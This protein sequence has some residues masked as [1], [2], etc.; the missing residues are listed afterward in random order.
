VART[1]E[2]EEP[3]RQE[4]AAWAVGALVGLA[5]GVLRKKVNVSRS[6]GHGQSDGGTGSSRAVGAV[7]DVASTFVAGPGWNLLLMGV[8]SARATRGLAA[9]EDGLHMAH[10]GLGWASDLRLL[11]LPAVLV[12][13]PRMFGIRYRAPLL[14]KGKPSPHALGVYDLFVLGLIWAWHRAFP[15]RVA[16]FGALRLPSFLSTRVEFV[17]TPTVLYLGASAAENFGLFKLIQA[18]G[19]PMVLSALSHS[20]PEVLS[21]RPLY[22]QS[23]VASA[24]VRGLP[25]YEYPQPT[26]LRVRDGDWER[27]VRDLMRVAPLVVLDVRTLAPHVK[28]EAAWISAGGHADKTIVVTEADE[29]PAGLSDEPLCGVVRDAASCLRLISEFTAD[30]GSLPTS[31]AAPRVPIAQAQASA[32][33]H[34]R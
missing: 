26:T 25:H 8:P 20:R 10:A 11:G 15:E 9:I 29:L 24:Y 7:V 16:P 23:R 22:R 21:G 34:A 14:W 18:S 31:Q 6:L 28:E 13:V 12:N 3:W 5:V 33:S 30:R 17:R 27:T 32:R 19:S 1:S 2:R 4:L